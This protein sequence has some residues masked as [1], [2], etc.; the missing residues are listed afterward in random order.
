MRKIKIFVLISILVTFQFIFP[1][2]VEARLYKLEEPEL[3]LPCRLTPK[4]IRRAIE[5]AFFF[6]RW[7]ANIQKDG[8]VIGRILV[9]RH[10]L[11]YRATYDTQRV[12]MHYL[13]SENLVYKE[14]DGKRYIHDRAND[15]IYN[16]IGALRSKLW[17]ECDS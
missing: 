11:S 5:G 1:D 13:K 15:W 17:M 3:E 7:T 10:M 4:Q 16:V 2:N 12:K 9:R 14:I 8:S 6:R